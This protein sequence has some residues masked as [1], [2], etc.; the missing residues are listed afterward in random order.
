[1]LLAAARR[2]AILLA[3]TSAI[4]LVAA[5]LGALLFGAGLFR[6]ISVAFYIVGSFLLVAGFFVGN[7]GPARPKEEAEGGSAVAGMFGIGI[8]TRGVRWATTEERDETIASSALFV[9]L[10]FLL[11]VIGFITDDSV[12]LH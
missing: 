8:A 11:I 9:T 4:T 7:R 12:R 1:M 3:G 5:L 6:A 10:G 2:L